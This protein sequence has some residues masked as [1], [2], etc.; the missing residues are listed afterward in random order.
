MVDVTT[1]SPEQEAIEPEKTE[2]TAGLAEP[3]GSTRPPHDSEIE[4]PDS[5][6]PAKDG[7]GVPYRNRAA[8]WKRKADQAEA[9]ARHEKE[10]RE[11]L[12]NLLVDRPDILEALRTGSPLPTAA[13][14]QANEGLDPETVRLLDK[15]MELVKHL[16]REVKS[17]KELALA[18][19]HFTAASQEQAVQQQ[20]HWAMGH[21]MGE[22]GLDPENGRLRTRV[23]DAVL[24]ELNRR[25]AAGQRVNGVAELREI[26]QEVFEDFTGASSKGNAKTR[27]APPPSTTRGAGPTAKTEPEVDLT[28]RAT[29]MR[30][31]DSLKARARG[32]SLE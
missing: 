6:P 25:N 31:L 17:A 10:Q 19:Q 5:E 24:S 22:V 28:D 18:S 23:T 26:A 16:A 15:P 14:G 30:M 11:E 12:E 29:R 9:S 1:E 27:T 21:F 8:E 32:A 13:P 3:I 4:D 20:F 7:K 2:S